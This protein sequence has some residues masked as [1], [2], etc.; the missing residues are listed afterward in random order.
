ME[1][2]AKGMYWAADQTD[3]LVLYK[4]EFCPSE[5]LALNEFEWLLIHECY[6]TSSLVCWG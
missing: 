4:K 5:V 2:Q 6:T 3:Q 1:Y